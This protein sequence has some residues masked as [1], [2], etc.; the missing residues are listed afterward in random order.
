MKNQSKQFI[1][2]FKRILPSP[3]TIAILLTV[4]TVLLAMF[5]TRP[6]E[7]SHGEY[8]IYLFS[9]W[10]EGLWDDSAGG[11]YFAFQMMLILVLGHVLALTKPVDNIIQALLHYCKSTA[12]SVFVVAIGS[13]IMGL[14]NWG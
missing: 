5:L 13:I 14:F 2:I 6:A 12:S 3:F 9:S 10:E 11:L 1:S 4:L 8:L 7:S